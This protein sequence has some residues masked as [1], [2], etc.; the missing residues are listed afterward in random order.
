MNITEQFL[1]DIGKHEMTVLRDEGVY[2]HIRFS[3]PKTMN[4]QFD[5][6]TWPGYLCYT[7]DMGTF[8][9]K[10]LDDMFRF[11]R[12]PSSAPRY[13][14]A[15]RYWGEKVEAGDRYDGIFEFSA[16]VFRAAVK[17]YFESATSDANRWSVQR[18]KVLWSVIESEVLAYAEDKE[19]YPVM[20]KL[21]D[22]DHDGF[23]FVDW[24][25][26]CTAPSLY[27]AWCCHALEWAIAVYDKSKMPG[28]EEGARCNRDGC[29]GLM[30]FERQ[31]DCS[32]HIRPPCSACVD[33]FLVCSECSAEPTGKE[34]AA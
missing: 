30:K 10:R 11:F 32:C 5:L 3:R 2:R 15:Y 25:D 24:E 14:Q 20:Q 23:Q 1:K 8:V 17:D 31:G 18:K 16:D 19:L 34:L 6:V 13:R 28:D 22:F 4:M 29:A 7:G 27:F 9:F 26:S 12:R 21:N 33:S